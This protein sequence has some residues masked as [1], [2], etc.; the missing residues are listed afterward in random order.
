MDSYFPWHVVEQSVQDPDLAKRHAVVREYLI[1]ARY[2]PKCGAPPEQLRWIYV[3]ERSGD[4]PSNEHAPS[5]EQANSFGLP[6]RPQC[7]EGYLLICDR[8][9]LQVDFFCE[10][11]R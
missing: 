2:C 3:R 11:R 5:G 7:R 10:R 9:H 1:E 6:V 4:I 8:C